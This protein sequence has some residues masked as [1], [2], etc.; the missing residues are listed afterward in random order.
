MSTAATRWLARVA[1]CLFG[2]GNSNSARPQ[3]A[4]RPQHRVLPYLELLENRLTRIFSIGAG[5]TCSIS[6]LEIARGLLSLGGGGGGILNNGDLTLTDIDLHDNRALTA[7]GVRQPGGAILNLEAL[8]KPPET[9]G[10]QAETGVLSEPLRNLERLQQLS[11]RQFCV[12]RWWRDRQ[13][14]RRRNRAR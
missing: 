14:R 12:W 1:C 11:P 9:L 2:L 4:R 3:G 8:T 6:G 5:R 7:G 10:K 13:H